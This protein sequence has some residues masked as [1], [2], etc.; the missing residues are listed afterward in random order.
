MISSAKRNLW[1]FSL[2][3]LIIVAFLTVLVGGALIVVMISG[4]ISLRSSDAYVLVQEEARKA[5][6]TMLQELRQAGPSTTGADQ[7]I[8]VNP[9]AVPPNSRL[10]FQMAIGY[11][12]A[13]CG[14]GACGNAGL[15]S[16]NS[17][18]SGV[19]WGDASDPTGPKKG[20][21]VHFVLLPSPVVLPTPTNQFIRCVTTGSGTRNDVIDGTDKCT[22]GFQVLANNVGNVQFI[23][24]SAVQKLWR[25]TLQVTYANAALPN[26]SMSLTPPGVTPLTAEVRLR[27]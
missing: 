10:D 4:P 24:V 9:G 20:N 3:E 8:Q 18:C 1:G 13:N 23:L 6:N 16:G 11:D 12:T 26:G 19:C 25:I 22:A 17:I 15:V 14:V 2:A 7:N 27:N 5:L 21:W